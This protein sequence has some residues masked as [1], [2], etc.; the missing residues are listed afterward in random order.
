MDLKMDSEN[1]MKSQGKQRA[2]LSLKRR[3]ALSA[4]VFV[5]PTLLLLLV[6]SFIPIFYSFWVSL[7]R[8]NLIQPPVYT[9]IENYINVF[10]D[11]YFRQALVNT[12]YFTGVSVPLTV[13]LSL[14][15]AIML[16]RKI[17]F[18]SFYRTGYYIPV[19]TSIVAVSVIWTWIY[20]GDTGLLNK[21]LASIGITG[22][23]WLFD[24][25][26]A[27]P[28]VIIMTIWKNVGYYMVIY[29]AGLQGIDKSYYEAAEID[30]ATRW[31]CFRHVTLPM[32]APT[33][34]FIVIMAV[35]SALQVFGQIYVMTGGG[36]VGST[37]TV[38]YLIYQ[39][40]F[41]AFKVGYASA[42][43]FIFFIVVFGLTLLQWK[44]SRGRVEFM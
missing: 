11:R 19:I 23:N 32:L 36:P 29:L 18:I 42:I 28:A 17:R 1:S 41:S 4:L 10:K 12:L 37:T 25:G 13:M 44:I 35:I 30:G 38:V 16:N 7:Q 43:A 31:N 9:G 22:P 5:S 27:M 6:F 34:Q 39:T 2:F 3:E 14:G 15:L 26:W 40:A 33:T 8:W 20:N 24:P 21:V